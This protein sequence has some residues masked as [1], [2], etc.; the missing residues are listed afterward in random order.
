MPPCQTTRDNTSSIRQCSKFRSS[1]VRCAAAGSAVLPVTETLPA[2]WGTQLRVPSKDKGR[3]IGYPSMEESQSHGATRI[4]LERCV[5]DGYY[6][7][8]PPW[9]S[10]PSAMPVH[11]SN[12]TY[13]YTNFGVH[14][15]WQQARLP[16]VT[17]ITRVEPRFACRANGGRGKVF[18]ACSQ[19]DPVRKTLFQNIYET[20]CDP[21]SHCD[22][23]VFQKR[24]KILLDNCS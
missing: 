23:P 20:G 18:A 4:S 19:G 10:H 16:T 21:A 12:A 22:P 17:E 15:N 7:E 14:R 1:W 9:D 11:L 13:F 5:S 3:P 24:N 6:L 8:I 2:S